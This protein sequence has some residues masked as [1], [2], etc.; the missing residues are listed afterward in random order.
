[1]TTSQLAILS[2]TRTTYFIKVYNA[3]ESYSS[4]HVFVCGPHIVIDTNILRGFKLFLT[5]PLQR[6][7]VSIA[8][9][10]QI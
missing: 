1:M 9:G 7:I 6:S 3:A 5:K 10:P 8:R 2:D 4:N